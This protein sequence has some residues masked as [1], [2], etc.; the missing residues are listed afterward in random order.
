MIG[1][2]T[3]RRLL[4]AACLVFLQAPQANAIMSVPVP[5]DAPV[6]EKWRASFAQFLRD[7]GISEAASTVDASKAAALVDLSGGPERMIFRVL[8]K[9]TCTPDRD[10]CLTIIAHIEKDALVSDAMFPA[11]GKINSGDVIREFLGA[12]SVPVFLYSQHKIVTIR[13]TARGLFVVNSP[14]EEAK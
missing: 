2:E 14:A 7:L 5:F 10:E 1:G 12:R 6:P 3:I 8:H 13:L 9:E 11:G 4:I